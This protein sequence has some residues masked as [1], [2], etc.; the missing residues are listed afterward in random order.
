MQSI[1]VFMGGISSERDISLRSGK[2]VSTALAKCG[3]KVLDVDIKDKDIKKHLNNIDAVFIALHGY[4]GEDGEVQQLLED[5][6][7]P[8][9]GSGPKS[10]ANCMNKLI[11]KRILEENNLPTPEYQIVKNINEIK[12]EL[13]YV[14]KATSEG[15]SFGV[16]IIHN[17]TDANK[18]FEIMKNDFTNF[19]VED[20]IKGAEVTVGIVKNKAGKLIVY[21]ILEL[22]PENEFY[23]F[24]AKYTPGKTSF[25]IPARLEENIYRKTLKIAKKAF[26]AL[27]CEGAA[28]V[29]FIIKGDQ[30]YITE[31]NT[32]PGMTTQSDLP[33]VATAKGET[34]EELIETIIKSADF[35]K[36]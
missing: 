20:F 15:S 36:Y 3:Y 25:I 31:I 32:I 28:R 21:P 22:E 27:K 7:I 30:P 33:A 34:F 5:L 8:Y 26:V 12:I 1:A 17:E 10:S 19:F 16:F 9:T 11:T 13:P 18:Q 4:F 29:D 24:E 35:K 2:N 23:D 14:L 6:E